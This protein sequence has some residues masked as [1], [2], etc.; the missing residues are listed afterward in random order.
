V[1]KKRKSGKEKEIQNERERRQANI[2]PPE[3][4][5]VAVAGFLTPFEQI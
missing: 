3:P 5:D 2:D 4:T 1:G